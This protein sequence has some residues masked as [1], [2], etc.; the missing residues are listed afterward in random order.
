[1]SQV[2]EQESIKSD[3]FYKQEIRNLLSKI[4]LNNEKMERDQEEIERLEAESKSNLHRIEMKLQRIESIL[5]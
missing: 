2:L 1:M 4:R 5:N 3:K